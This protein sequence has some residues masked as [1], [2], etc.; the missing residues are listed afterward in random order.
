V[1]G[2][3]FFPRVFSA[4]FFPF[5]VVVARYFT[6]SLIG[7]V[8]FAASNVTRALVACTRVFFFVAIWIMLHPPLIERPEALPFAVIVY[9]P[10][11]FSA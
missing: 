9:L 4:D 10:F 11:F 7:A 5:V 3:P 2:L 6:R 8:F 1:S